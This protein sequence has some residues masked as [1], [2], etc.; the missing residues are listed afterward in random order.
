MADQARALA[1]FATGNPRQPTPPH[2]HRV[3]P[4]TACTLDGLYGCAVKI[5][6]HATRGTETIG[7]MPSRAIN[8][9]IENK[10]ISVDTCSCEIA[11]FETSCS[12][13]NNPSLSME[14]SNGLMTDRFFRFRKSRPGPEEA[15]VQTFL[16]QLKSKL[17]GRYF[18]LREPALTSGYPDIVLCKIKNINL[19][20]NS[21]RTL[22]TH[23]HIR[24]M[25]HLHHIR[26]AR[27][28]QLSDSLASSPRIVSRLI[29][30]LLH[31]GLATEK[32]GYIRPASL[33]RLF[34]LSRI[35]SI[36]AKVGAWRKAIE[37]AVL[38]KWFASHSYV[39]IPNQSN[40]REIAI[41]ASQYGVGVIVAQENDHYTLS[42]PRTSK[43]PVSYASWLFNE[44]ALRQCWKGT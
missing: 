39:L 34:T 10:V 25:H 8:R 27:I 35:I 31:L 13:M 17:T 9:Y 24:I 26:G 20:Y 1:G 42:E 44:W 16:H 32:G 21:E 12:R 11:C 37:Q 6:N 3:G 18:V 33:D 40:I 5:P 19:P 43:L 7:I 14:C 4:S 41:A 36:E 28:E 22:L 38:N 29:S 15:L 23:K 30:D 2:A